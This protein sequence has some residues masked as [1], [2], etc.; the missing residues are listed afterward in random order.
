[1]S[2]IHALIVD[3][4]LQ[5]LKVLA[6]LL[7]RQGVTTTE[8]S[9]P[10]T[11]EGLL[12]TLS[13]VNVVFLDLEMPELDGFTVKDLIKSQLGGVPVIA[14]TVHVSEINLAKARGFDGLL[15]KPLDKTRFP[16]QLARILNGEAVWERT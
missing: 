3:D 1:M 6:Q 14:Y 13:A 4:N 8:V 15:G 12:P 9:N 2:Q 16:D 5:N 11:L 10:V 7:A